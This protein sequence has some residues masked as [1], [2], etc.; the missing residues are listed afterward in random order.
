MGIGRI[1]FGQRIVARG[2]IAAGSFEVRDCVHFDARECPERHRRRPRRFSSFLVD[3][4]C[5][6]SRLVRC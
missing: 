6:V 5:G 1:R 3:L 4:T 2:S